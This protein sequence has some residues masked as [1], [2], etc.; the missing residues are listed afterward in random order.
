MGARRKAREGVLLA[1]YSREISGEQDREVL[2]KN[3]LEMYEIPKRTEMFYRAL[4]EETLD[5]ID[6]I[7]EIIE[8]RVQNWD[9]DRIVIVDRNILRMGVA[10]L[11]YFPDIPPK[12]SI[13]ECIE[14]AKLYG[15]SES[16]RFVNGLLDAILRFSDLEKA[17]ELEN[18]E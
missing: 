1:L 5:H 16:A 17:E 8:D 3:I 12:T 9:L 10:E 15:T 13:N 18:K 7:D 14:L 6:E 11:F 4:L 2:E